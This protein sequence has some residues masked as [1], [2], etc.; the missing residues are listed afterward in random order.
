MR[1]I[2]WKDNCMQAKEQIYSL[3]IERHVLG[4]LINNPKIFSEIERFIT[5]KDFFNDVNSTIFCVIRSILANN[6]TLDKILI[7]EKI[8]NLQ[9]KFQEQID[10]YRYIDDIS[11][12]QITPKAVKEASQE[13]LKY[14]IRR[15]ISDVG[16]ELCDYAK[17][18]GSDD[19]DVIISTCDEKYSSRM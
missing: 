3:K 18:C 17:K 1:V 10:I 13:L 9:I 16:Q 4:G 8:Q 19:I 5:E 15:G 14:N 7:A 12:T 2:N 6:Q 11:F